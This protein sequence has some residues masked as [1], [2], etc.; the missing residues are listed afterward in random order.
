MADYVVRWP[1]SHFKESVKIASMEAAAACL[2]DVPIIYSQSGDLKE[3]FKFSAILKRPY[4]LVT[5]QSDFSPRRSTILSRDRN[6]AL[7][8]AQNNDV[9]HPRVA[10]LPIGLNCFEHAPEMHQA[11]RLLG[12]VTALDKPNTVL[13]NFGNTH[14]SR[15]DVWDQFCGVGKTK[16]TGLVTCAIKTQQNNIMNN[17]HLV[18]YYQ[19]VASHKFVVAP[20]GNGWDTHRLWEALYLGCVPIVMSSPL[21]PLYEEYPV[22]IVSSW[23]DVTPSALQNKYD[24]FRPRLADRDSLFR[25]HWM[26][27]IE[28]ARQRILQKGGL[29]N[30]NSSRFRCWGP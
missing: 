6:L 14:P 19:K 22:W 20:R 29:T 10:H 27:V 30:G 1:F 7:W 23:S 11:L 26:R 8:F 28:T 4:I 3:M 24:E 17:P 25:D 12:D 5:G 9:A 21:D 13:V 18:S 15:R 2:P 16:Y